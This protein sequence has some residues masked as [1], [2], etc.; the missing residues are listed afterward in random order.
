MKPIPELVLCVSVMALATLVSGCAT[1]HGDKQYS[2]RQRFV[3]P[4]D[5]GASESSR[6]GA[7]FSALVP[8][9]DGTGV[10]RLMAHAGIGDSFP[11]KDEEGRCFFEVKVVGGDDD[12]LLILINSIEAPQRI[13]LKR[14]KSAWFQIGKN[15]Y[16]LAYPSVSVSAGKNETPTTSQAMLL[17]HHHP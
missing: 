11:I 8:L 12:H 10:S 2:V 9:K 14:D 15:K 1:Q 3:P 16:D 7:S 4:P 6:N 5:A 17:V 13:D